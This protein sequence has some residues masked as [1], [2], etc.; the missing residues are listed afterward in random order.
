M[1]KTS[2]KKA[3]NSENPTDL[4]AIIQSLDLK[5]YKNPLKLKFCGNKLSCGQLE[6]NDQISMDT[7]GVIINKI[8][9][10]V[11]VLFNTFIFINC[12]LYFIMIIIFY[13]III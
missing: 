13:Y 8:I 3:A 1:L 7:M 12:I 9:I 4:A 6:K 5:K 2:E 10:A 11:K